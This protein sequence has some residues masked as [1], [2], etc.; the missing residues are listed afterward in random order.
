LAGYHGE[1]FAG[2]GAFIDSAPVDGDPDKMQAYWGGYCNHNNVLFP[3]WHRVYVLKVEE[4]LQSIVPDVMLPYWDETSDESVNEG[5]PWAL[6][7]ET[8][9]LDDKEIQNPLISYVFP[10]KVDDLKSDNYTYTKQEGYTTVRYPLSGLVGTAEARVKTLIH[11]DKY[12]D[13]DTNVGLL[14]E[15]V[16]A[17]IFSG[18]THPKKMIDGEDKKPLPN[19]IYDKYVRCLEAPNYTVFSNK[20]SSGTWNDA[21]GKGDKRNFVTALEDP[22]NTIHL[23]VGGFDIPSDHFQSGE[24]AGANGDMGENNTAA[25]DPIF[26]FHHCNVDRMFWVW[27]KKHGKTDNFEIIPGYAGT[28]SSDGQGPTPNFPL[29]ASLSMGS[30]LTPFLIDPKTRQ[31]MYTSN[32]V[33]NIETQLGFTYSEG[34]LDVDSPELKSYNKLSDKIHKGQSQRTLKIS[35]INRELFQGSFVVSAYASIDGEDILL[36][37]DT[38]LSR[39]SVKQCANCMNHLEVV[40]FIPLRRL[41]DAQ[42]DKAE[43]KVKISH[44]RRA[45]PSGLEYKIEVVG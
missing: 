33:V 11:N 32:D 19:S 38:I 42:V 30:P 41:T 36:G 17:W 9:T 8:I 3:T 43:F 31:Q 21:L 6:T 26:F 37:S 25:F 15:N 29:D 4:A 28:S 22:H 24:L 14:N 12:P 10:A 39:W 1:P 7:R 2:A 16:K 5:I 40:S 45:L 44:R 13:Y 35:G 18:P 20:T 34:S 27:Q 23:S